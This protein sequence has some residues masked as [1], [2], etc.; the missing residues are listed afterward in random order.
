MSLP[1]TLNDLQFSGLHLLIQGELT[2]KPSGI[3]VRGLLSFP[4]K[5]V[6][7]APRS[8][9]MWPGFEE[10]VAVPYYNVWVVES[11]ME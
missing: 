2:T 10:G 8:W 6:S 7:F 11:S 9:V 1:A 3:G 4:H 5:K